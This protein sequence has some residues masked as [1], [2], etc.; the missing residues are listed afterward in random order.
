MYMHW[1]RA[2]GTKSA[3]ELRELALSSAG[4]VLLILAAIV[5][6]APPQKASVATP[7]GV[8]Q[9]QA[10]YSGGYPSPLSCPVN[11]SLCHPSPRRIGT[12]SVR[13]PGG[14]GQTVNVYSNGATDSIGSAVSFPDSVNRQVA[15]EWACQPF[16]T[17]T[18][19]CSQ[20]FQCGCDWW[21]GCGWC[22][23]S[24]ECGPGTTSYA[25][26]TQGTG[27]NTGDALLGNT[28]VTFPNGYTTNTYS[29]RCVDDAG[30]TWSVS[31]VVYASAPPPPPG[32]NPPTL[33]ANISAS[34]QTVSW[35]NSSAVTWVSSQSAA[36]CTITPAL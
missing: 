16:Q 20:G 22:T 31:A 8:S 4:V 7:L 27:F 24:Y 17:A 6:S 25:D 34:P 18:Q 26:R 3:E 12:L 19:T 33:F 14:S 2:L 30:P 11:S 1:R 29:L 28:T 15:V 35:G 9:G 10:D 23:H 36:Q 5:L 13:T 32:N 21:G